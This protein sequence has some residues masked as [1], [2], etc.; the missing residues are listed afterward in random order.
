M[1]ENLSL[2]EFTKACVATR[3]RDMVLTF[4]E[5]NALRNALM[6]QYK[7]EPMSWRE[8]VSEQFRRI[9]DGWEVMRGRADIANDW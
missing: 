9:K 4:M 5:P 7:P 6:E 2:E 3:H 8:R 1:A